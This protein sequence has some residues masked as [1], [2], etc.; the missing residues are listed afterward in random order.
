MI[1]LLLDGT[2]LW[3]FVALL[4][5][6]F[7]TAASNKSAGWCST[8]LG[9]GLLTLQFFSNYHPFSFF[10]EQPIHAAEY[11]AAYA[12][13]GVLYCILKWVSYVGQVGRKYKRKKQEYIENA[14]MLG[15]TF[16]DADQKRF[17]TDMTHEFGFPVPIKSL[18][19]MAK[20]RD[21]VYLWIAFW[22]LSAIITVFDDPVRRFLSFCYNRL[23]NLML[24][25]AKRAFQ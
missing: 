15:N 21:S 1:Y 3:V 14:K 24:S 10:I 6:G 8:L 5:V 20:H 4:S 25:I 13:F 9:G 2:L 23:A 12:F 11:T 22:P 19:D 17:D 18:A 7:L 16:T